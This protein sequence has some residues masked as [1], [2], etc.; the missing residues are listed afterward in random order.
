M[1]FRRIKGV[2]LML[3][4]IV[5][6]TTVVCADGARSWCIDHKVV[7]MNF[8]GNVDFMEGGTFSKSSIAYFAYIGGPDKDLSL[9]SIDANGNFFR[10][11]SNEIGTLLISTKNYHNGNCV[12]EYVASNRR[13]TTTQYEDWLKKINVD[14]QF[15]TSSNYAGESFT[16]D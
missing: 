11:S 16:V 6:S 13:I 10:G 15:G 5:A 2:I 9:L 12:K 7:D 1:K 14:L 4:L 3:L 8:N